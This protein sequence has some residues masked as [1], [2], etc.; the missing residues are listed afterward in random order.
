MEQRI[1]FTGAGRRIELLQAFRQ[2]SLRLGVS[3]KII[4]ADM[5]STA[6]ALPFCDYGRMVC[7]M[8]DEAYIPTLLD[9]CRRDQIDLLIPT[10]DTDLRLLADHKAEFEA[11]GTRVMV[12][13]PEM[14]AKCRD[15][16][17][18]ADFF[19]ECGLHAP[20][21]VNSVE[22][23]SGPYPCFIKPKDG[24][25][26]IGANRADDIEGLRAFAGQLD[27]Y[28][29]QPYIDGE[30]FTVDIF[31][32]FDGNPITIIPRRRLAVRSG[33]VLKTR[34]ALDDQIISECEK[35]IEAFKPCG[36]MT[37]QLIRQASTGTDY[38]IEINPRFGGGAPLSMKAGADSAEAILRLLAGEAVIRKTEGLADG[39]VY[40]R[41]DQSVC[42]ERGE[43]LPLRGIIFDLDDTLC[44][45]KDYV[46]SGYA[47]VAEALP[48]VAD[49]A[50]RLWVYFEAG[51]PAIDCLLEEEGLLH[52]KAEVLDAYHSHKPMLKLDTAVRTLLQDLRAAGMKLGIITDGRPEGQRNKIAAL[53]LAELVDEIIVTDEL[54][55]PG[56]R[57]PNDIAFRI[58]QCRLGIPFGQ[59]AYVGDNPVKDFQAPRQLGMMSIWYDNSEGIYASDE[60]AADFVI[61]SLT[62]IVQ[63]I[64]T[65][66][67]EKLPTSQSDSCKR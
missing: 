26:S 2:A 12:S 67:C 42:V 1:L 36:P 41:F 55:G 22:A 62:D 40:S 6:P 17:I 48:E 16:N 8:R 45:E 7:S 39:A 13:E 54:G 14:I 31:C 56:F 64:G 49:A 37:V 47:A 11:V 53:D 27:D 23:Y 4:G 15:K 63:F 28:V 19:E 60:A 38:F 46:R 5:V 20:R 33:E 51:K 34:I 44:L 52:R 35:L 9:I 29:I 30:E 21:T 61:E 65:E 66:G 43:G 25:S 10:I 3:L 59:L 58:M 18:T 24:S 50:E 57:K 32:D